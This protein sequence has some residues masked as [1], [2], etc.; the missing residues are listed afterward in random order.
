MK[1]GKKKGRRNWRLF[2]DLELVYFACCIFPVA[3]C[4]AE[5]CGL[6]FTIC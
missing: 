2:V 1:T 3:I 4:A 5:L 6:S